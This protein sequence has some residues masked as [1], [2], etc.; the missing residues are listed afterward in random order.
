MVVLHIMFCANIWQC[1]YNIICVILFILL[2]SNSVVL[3][4]VLN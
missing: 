2:L 3:L 1:K 4:L